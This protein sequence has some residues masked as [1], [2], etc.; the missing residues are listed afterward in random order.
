LNTELTRKLA[1]GLNEYLL[2]KVEVPR[3]RMG[4]TQEVETLINEEAYV[5]AMYLRNERDSWTA[6]IAT[7]AT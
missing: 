5:L 1:N 6:R 7:L 2:S 4:N 3:I